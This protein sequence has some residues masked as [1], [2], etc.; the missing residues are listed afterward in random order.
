MQ[1]ASRIKLSQAALQHGELQ[2]RSMLKDRPA[3]SRFITPHDIIWKYAVRKFA[4]EDLPDTIDWSHQAP[5]YGAEAGHVYPCRSER[6]HIRIKKISGPF[7]FEKLWARVIFEFH[8]MASYLRTKQVIRKADAGKLSRKAFIVEM[9]KTEF[10]A[11]L[12]TEKFYKNVWEDWAKK[13]GLW[14]CPYEWYVGIPKNFKDWIRYYDKKSIY[15]WKVYSDFYDN[16][17]EKWALED[18]VN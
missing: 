16:H 3:M 15:P 6:G 10:K 5:Y 8:N 17:L 14:S 18:R 4:G 9:A 7:A 11:V 1:I 13:K 2:V 12:V